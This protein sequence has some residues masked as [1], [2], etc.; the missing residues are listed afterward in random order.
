M[1]LVRL[2]DECHYKAIIDRTYP[3]T[4]IAQAH[5]FVDA[6]RKRGN[7]IVQVAAELADDVEAHQGGGAAMGE[8]SQ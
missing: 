5:R 2:A 7:V 4:E 6:G 3:L 1:A 8:D